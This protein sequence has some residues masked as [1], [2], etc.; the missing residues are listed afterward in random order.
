[1][2][3]MSKR[4]EVPYVSYANSLGQALEIGPQ[5]L[6][7]FSNCAPS[8]VTFFLILYQFGTLCV[9]LLFSASNLKMVVDDNTAKE[10]H[11]SLWLYMTILLVP[12]LLLTYIKNLRVLAPF[13]NV[14][15][16]LTIA[17][18]IIVYYFVFKKIEPLSERDF[19]GS[20]TTVA[21]FIGTSMFAVLSIGIVNIFPISSRFFI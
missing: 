19:S 13:S 11:L 6:R 4:N 16:W 12:I 14:A 15:N 10:S 20:P 1:M 18:L 2:L 3:F 21:L 7:K 9:Y 5:C 8:L 17:S